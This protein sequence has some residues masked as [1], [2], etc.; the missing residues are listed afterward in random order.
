M[1]SKP[2][3]K[4]LGNLVDLDRGLVDREIFTSEELYQQQLERIFARAWLFVGHESQIPNPNDFFVSRMGEESVIMTRDRQGEIQ[5]LLN[6]CRHRGMKVCRYDEG[7]TPVFSC[8]Y[9]GWSYSTDG[10]LVSVPGEL[11]GV[12]QFQTAYHG[13]LKREDWGLISV[14]Q[15]INYKGAI[16]ATWDATAPPFEKYMGDM[17]KLFDSA[18]SSA[19]GSPN[20]MEV[21][22]G[23]Q[24]FIIPSSWMY[25]AENFIGD[26]YHGI[27]HRSVDIAGISP[28]GEGRHRRESGGL[29]IGSVSFP[30]LGHGTTGAIR[31]SADAEYATTWPDHPAVDEFYRLAFERRRDAVRAGHDLWRCQASTIFPNMSML[32]DPSSFFVWHPRGAMQ[33]ELWRWFLVEKDAPTEA[34]DAMRH[35]ALR[36]SGPAGMTEQ[37]DSENWNFA[38]AA[39]KGVVARRY[40]FNY[41]MGL[42]RTTQ[43]E[44]LEGA[45]VAAFVSENNARTLYKRWAEFMDSETWDELMP[46]RNSSST[47]GEESAS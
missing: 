26:N 43:V 13:E 44:D 29:T 25:G 33:M 5:V 7:N 23:V 2:S 27:S 16:F 45:E 34:K 32:S 47:K 10:K 9:H 28:Q 39:S 17:L 22:G 8:P 30:D 14:P 21:V 38:T 3:R 18:L 19:D 4:I 12:P 31:I 36:Y 42:G 6:T 11:I 35:F 24:K 20:G 1:V 40:A 15:L 41:Q 46:G 37:D